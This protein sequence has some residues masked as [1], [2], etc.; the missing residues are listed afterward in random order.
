MYAHSKELFNP[1]RG[2][3]KSSQFPQHQAKT[4]NKH[5]KKWLR[6]AMFQER[7]QG[8]NINKH[9]SRDPYKNLAEPMEGHKTTDE[10][11]TAGTTIPRENREYS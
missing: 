6:V 10:K 7:L 3:H 8:S 5:E 1:E 11:I 4:F 9:G 2:C